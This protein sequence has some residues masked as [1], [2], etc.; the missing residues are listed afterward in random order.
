MMNTLIK[1]LPL[2]GFVLAGIF[3]FAFTEP[4][5]NTP[6]YQLVDG[7]VEDVS[8]WN[9]QCN[10]P[11]TDVCTYEDPELTIPAQMGRFEL[12]P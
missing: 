8:T 7:Q 10:N 6:L 3:A 5:A 12:I 9:Y 1:R 4:K 11:Q 2:L